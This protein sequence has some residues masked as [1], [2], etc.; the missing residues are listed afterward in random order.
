MKSIPISSEQSRGSHESGLESIY[1]T[2]SLGNGLTSHHRRITFIM[3]SAGFLGQ[4]SQ[5][6]ASNSSFDEEDY[7]SQESLEDEDTLFGHSSEMIMDDDIN[8]HQVLQHEGERT[9]EGYLAL[10]G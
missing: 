10:C 9:Q 6:E 5:M 1:G 8:D 2:T 3:V 7:E 4:T